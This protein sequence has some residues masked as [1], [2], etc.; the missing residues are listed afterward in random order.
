LSTQAAH[1]AHE[2][3]IIAVFIGIF[4]I[5]RVFSGGGFCRILFRHSLPFHFFKKLFLHFSEQ[6][7]HYCQN[8]ISLHCLV[9]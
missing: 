2:K 6:Q 1:G 8:N 3:A 5:F 4:R 9:M 7:L